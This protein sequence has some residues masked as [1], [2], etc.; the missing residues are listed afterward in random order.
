MRTLA[1]HLQTVEQFFVG[2]L[3]N[4]IVLDPIAIYSAI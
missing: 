1:L 2:P 4:E 3:T